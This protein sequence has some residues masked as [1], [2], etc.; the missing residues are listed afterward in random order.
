MIQ[1]LILFLDSGIPLLSKYLRLPFPYLT[2]D[3][4][5]D[6]RVRQAPYPVQKY[7]RR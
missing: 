6:L 2:P 1:A 4:L 7:R 3:S 5:F